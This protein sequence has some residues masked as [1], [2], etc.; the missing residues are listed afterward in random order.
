MNHM[1]KND[2]I[3]KIESIQMMEVVNE[4]QIRMNLVQSLKGEERILDCGKSL[5]TYFNEAQ[6][7]SKEI[8]TTDINVFR[9]YPDIRA[10]ICDEIEFKK[11]SN[12]FDFVICFSLIEH[13]Y[14]PF[15]ACKNLFAICKPGGYIYGSAPFLFPRHSPEDLSYQDFFRFTR[16]AYALLFP[17]AKSIVLYPLR[18][19][20][21]TALNVLSLRYRFIFEKIFPNFS[22]RISR[23]LSRDK[24]ALQ[25]SGYAFVISK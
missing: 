3:S 20:L 7:K 13:T 25:A 8:L 10:D 11:Y 16:D 22:K 15:L 19:R 9:N 21:A 23:L 12:S 4:D 5:R 14:N 18:G 17:D 24:N 1:K 6:A 2:I